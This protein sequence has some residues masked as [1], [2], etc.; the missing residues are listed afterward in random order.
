[1]NYILVL[2]DMCPQALS[3]K[4]PPV[5]PKNECEKNA[6]CAPDKQCCNTGC[7]KQCI[8]APKP[9]PGPPAPPSKSLNVFD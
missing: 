3:V 2:P 7:H 4:C 1:M 9:K 6:D 5:R 8:K